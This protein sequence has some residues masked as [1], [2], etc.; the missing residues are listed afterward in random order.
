MRDTWDFDCLETGRRRPSNRVKTEKAKEMKTRLSLAVASVLMSTV[1]ALGQ[2]HYDT[3]DSPT[4]A[5]KQNASPNIVQPNGPEPGDISRNGGRPGAHP[6][7]G[8]TNGSAPSAATS[9]GSDTSSNRATGGVNGPV[10]SGITTPT[11]ITAPP[12]NATTP[13]AARD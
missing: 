4:A 6:A 11:D 5:T 13:G 1:V 12:N 3:L 10:N 8:A 2:Q 7:V 9:P